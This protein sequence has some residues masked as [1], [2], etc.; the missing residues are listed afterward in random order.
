MKLFYLLLITFV[1]GEYSQTT[2]S[3]EPMAAEACVTSGKAWAKQRATY[4]YQC[5]GPV[6]R[7]ADNRND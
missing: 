3:P 1:P 6:E 7:A 4:T 5:I 2:W